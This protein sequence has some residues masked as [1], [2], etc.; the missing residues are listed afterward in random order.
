[1]SCIKVEINQEKNLIS[2]WNNGEGIPVVMHK[3]EKM[4]VPTMIFGHLL[5]SSNYNDEEQKVTGGRN[6]YGAKLCNIFST[7]FTVETASKKYKKGFKQIWGANMTKTSEPKIREEFGEDFTKISFSPDLQKFKME[8]LDDDIVALMSRR[9]F[10]IAASTRGISVFLNGE[11]IPVKSFKEYIDLYIKDKVDDMGNPLKVVYESA[12][13]RWEIAATISDRGFQQVSFVNSIATMK[14]GRHV[15]YV[16]D[17]MIKQLIEVLKK[18]NKG[19]IQIKPFQV[20][21]HIWVFV[22]CLIVN[23]TFDS[24]TKENMTLQSKSFGSKCVLPDKFIT[25]L[26]RSGIVES[27]LS[28]AKFKAQ[29]E[30]S[31]TSGKK[32]TKI[33][34]VPKLEDANN[35]GTKNSHLCTLILTEGDSAKSLA[36]SGLGVIG[37]D[38]Y[39]VF[40]LRGK[41][42]N[43]RE[44]THKQILE[45]AE[46]NNL[47]KIV[48]L[49]YK[50]KY[51]TIDSLKTL[52]YGKVMIMTDQDQDGSHI[53]GLLINFIHNNWP[54]LLRLPFLEEFITPIVKA[55]KNKEELSFYSLPEF[56]EWKSNTPNHKTYNV[57]YYK[58]LGTSTSKEAKEY[59]QDM[60][61]HRITFDYDGSKDDDN[62]LMAFSKKCIDQ[63]KDWLT[64]HMDDVRQRKILGL[65]DRYLYTK[66]TKS[67]SYSDFINLELVLFSNMDNS[68]SIPC[69][70]DGLKPGQRK[71]LFTC[72]KRND[73]KEVKVAQLAGSV[74][75]KSAYHHGEVSLCGTI[76]NLAQNYVG[77]NN[78]NLLMPNGQFGTRLQG[79]K[80]SAS[81]RYIFTMMSPLTR[82]I[83][84]P[85]DDPLLQQQLDDNLKIEPVWYLP[86]IPMILVNGAEG[87]GTGWSTKVPNFNPRDIIANIRRMIQGDQ[88]KPMHPWYKN[89][90][91]SI[92]KITDIRYVSSGNIAT[93]GDN[94]I[95]ISE[96][97][98]GVWTQ[99]FKENVL[100]PLYSGS[101]KQKQIISDYKEYH[102]DTTVRFVITLLPAEYDNLD[103]EEGGFHRIFKQ[104]ASLNLAQMHA[105]DANNF[106]KR[107]ENVQEILKE[108]YE[109]RLGFYGKRKEYMLGQLQAEAKQLSNQA[110]FILE[111]CN[112]TLVV[113][114]KK[115]KV[116][117][118]ELISRGYDPDPI[119]AWKDKIKEESDEDEAAEEEEEQEDAK[120]SKSSKPVDPEK[121]F[122][123]LTDVKK[124]NYLLG[125]S[126]WM[127]T[128]EK[129]NEILKQRDTKLAEV[130]VLEAKTIES[131][132]VDDLDAFEKKLTEVEEKER[133][134][135]SGLNLKQQ[136]AM[137]KMAPQGVKKR[138][139]AAVSAATRDIYPSK[140]GVRIEFRVTDEVLKKYDKIAVSKEKRVKKEKDPDVSGEPDEF[141]L[142]AGESGGV[143]TV[144]Q[145]N[146]GDAKSKAKKEPAPKKPPV[147]KEPKSSEDKPKRQPKKKSKDDDDA[148][149]KTK[150]RSKVR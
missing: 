133:A 37:R 125:M 111:K 18:K 129:K 28:W 117:V 83:F 142:M 76:V 132:W 39:G 48:G 130:S 94:K 150:G 54:E 78:I 82:L 109:L 50:Q 20:K 120:P 137:A 124:F 60:G 23:P 14:G 61:R 73:K 63:R 138:G 24:Q 112:K 47:I 80:D 128:E 123:R 51:L 149:K 71:V 67:I 104:T 84:H 85:A 88:P 95:E 126:M 87:I 62:I 11:K 27:V 146:G 89:F 77:S 141:D 2:V 136:K 106:L 12:G 114:N 45:N 10:D 40:P 41:L 86:I 101:E 34:G 140:D 148:P 42:L 22:N 99:A 102:T 97:P 57:K 19:G 53:K 144:S 90:K 58:G 25:G 91:G 98:V 93:L 127:L 116:I 43:V 9:A 119:Q 134:E 113:E 143:V 1:M 30:L 105:F 110:R 66:N 72:F 75:E 69:M 59:F 5:T 3:D 36:V 26:T 46:I 64:K 35:A 32:N 65:P 121:A 74:A 21:N 15:D 115:R 13:E 31:K 122:Q 108:F 52:R 79:G 139:G 118:D 6:G 29:N 131:L 135:E 68:R 70:V 49:Q 33:K 16:V 103:R 17:M 147:K 96:L 44:A 107:Y 81:P 38:N 145:E 56:E 4:F 100:E 55:V 92:D 8:T 7:M